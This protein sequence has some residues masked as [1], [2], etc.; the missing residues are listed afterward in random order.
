MADNY[1]TF[2][3]LTLFLI[4]PK[5]MAYINRYFHI[6]YYFTIQM[7]MSFLAACSYDNNDLI[8]LL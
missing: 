2:T 3:I 7:T 8:I 6:V 5:A 1:V 4:E